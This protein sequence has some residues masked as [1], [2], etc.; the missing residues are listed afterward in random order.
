VEKKILEAA[1]EFLIISIDWNYWGL[2]Y[3][4][5]G[6]YRRSL[7]S[8]NLVAGLCALFHQMNWLLWTCK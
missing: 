2:E 8:Y 3:P 5:N 7:V 4:F 1:R 6:W